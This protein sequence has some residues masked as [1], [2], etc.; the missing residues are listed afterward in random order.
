MNLC[1]PEKSNKFLDQ[2][3]DCQVNKKGSVLEDGVTYED[4]L[5]IVTERIQRS[6]SERHLPDAK[7][8][9]SPFYASPCFLIL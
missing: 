4:I 1:F 3:S 9:G 5:N 8:Q 6:T 7:I 2:V